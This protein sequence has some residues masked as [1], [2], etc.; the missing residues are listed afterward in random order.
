MG[1]NVEGLQS[2]GWGESGRDVSENFSH[3]LVRPSAAVVAKGLLLP[4]LVH[5]IHDELVV[6]VCN[7]SDKTDFNV[8]LDGDDLGVVNSG[9]P[10]EPLAFDVDPHPD[11]G[12][13]EL[14]L[15][16]EAL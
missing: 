10:L 7:V 14:W 16:L 2:P 6:I 8:V 9:F 3:Q 5:G 1:E 4:T 13:P 15:P 11:R 12:E